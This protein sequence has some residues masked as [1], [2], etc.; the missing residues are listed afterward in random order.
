[1]IY[2]ILYTVLFFIVMAFVGLFL[3]IEC[4]EKL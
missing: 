2:E 3:Y 1:M 4:K